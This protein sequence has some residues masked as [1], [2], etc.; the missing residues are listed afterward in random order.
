MITILCFTHF[1][2]CPIRLFANSSVSA[3]R[4]LVWLQ[5]K[6]HIKAKGSSVVTALDCVPLNV[7][8]PTQH[9]AFHLNAN[10]LEGRSAR[11]VHLYRYLCILSCGYHKKINWCRILGKRGTLLQGPEKMRAC[12]VL[13]KKC[14]MWKDIFQFIKHRGEKNSSDLGDKQ[15]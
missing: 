9:C 5:N 10:V 13:L 14:L 6:V 11:H 12:F 8:K 4:G 2:V 3:C 7:C 1:V 15:K